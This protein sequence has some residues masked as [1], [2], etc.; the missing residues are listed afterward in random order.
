MDSVNSDIPGHPLVSTDEPKVD[1]FVALVVDMRKS[2]QRLKTIVKGPKI[3]GFQR[4]YYETSALLPGVAVVCDLKD[5]MVTEYLGDGALVLFSVD[6][7]DR[8]AS[9]RAAYSAAKNCLE[10]LRKIINER[11][12]NKYDLPP[13]DLG[14]GLAMSDALVTVV[15]IPGNYQPKAVGSCVWDASKLSYG[16]NTIHV[17]QGIKDVWPSGKGGTMSFTPLD[18]EHIKGYRMINNV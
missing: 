3:Q 4:L 13:I 15:G 10:D 11:L 7:K 14:A 18:K 8:A 9:V 6:K 5:G 12:S 17:A 1:E 2:T 16:T